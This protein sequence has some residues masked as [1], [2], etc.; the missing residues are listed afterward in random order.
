MLSKPLP[1]YSSATAAVPLLGE[2][3]GAN[4]ERTVARYG[5]REALVRRATDEVTHH[6]L[7]RIPVSLV[8]PDTFE[9]AVLKSRRVIDERVSAS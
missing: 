5:D 8:E 4:L 2:T 3:I 7:V 6:C 9:R 1:S